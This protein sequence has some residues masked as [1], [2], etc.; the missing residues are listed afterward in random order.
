[1]WPI[2]TYGCESWTL[3]K[4][5]T[6]GIQA[7]ELRCYRMALRIPYVDHVTNE[8]VLQRVNQKRL[9]LGKIQSQKL[10]YF[11]HIAR[12]PSMQNDINAGLHGWDASAKKT[13]E[14]KEDSG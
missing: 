3:K 9:L 5:T 10:Q 11:V 2:V 6:E 12:H 4:H 14:G 8:E 7:F 13:K 1:V